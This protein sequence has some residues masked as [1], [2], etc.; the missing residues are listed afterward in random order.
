MDE[1]RRNHNIIVENGTKMTLTGVNDVLSFDDETII[2]DT[3]LGRLTI[4]GENLHITNFDTNSGDLSA[5]GKFY[6]FVYTVA[7]K[8]GG[9]FSRIFK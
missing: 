2:L 1:I 3:A 6:A 5:D 7:E 8:G 4:K 9:L